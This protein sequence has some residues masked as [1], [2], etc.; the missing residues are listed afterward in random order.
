MNPIID[1]L[2]SCYFVSIATFTYII[3]N[4]TNNMDSLKFRLLEKED[5]NRGYLELL[6]QLTIIGNISNEKFNN[7]FDKI[8]TEIWVIEEND[9]IIVSASLFLEQKIIHEGG[10]V[11]HLEDV[12]V[13]KK[14][15]RIGLGKFII[16]KIIN[17]A[18]E[19]GCYKLIGDCKPELVEF[20]K[21]N[22]F[23][24]NSVQISMYY[25]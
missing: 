8:K 3:F 6:K 20:Y 11:G 7:I 15:R 24:S 17:I 2:F 14:H 16:C 9:K 25:V 23:E 18:K 12:V 13:D 22:G 4:M 1:A 10:V 19:R 21:K 5:Y